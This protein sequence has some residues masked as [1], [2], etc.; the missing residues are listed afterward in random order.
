MRGKCSLLDCGV[1]DGLAC[2]LGHIELTECPH[3][4]AVSSDVVDDNS[5]VLA[6]DGS[7]SDSLGAV[8]HWG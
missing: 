6:D 7:V 4:K 5:S 2:E 8:G 1:K 3:F